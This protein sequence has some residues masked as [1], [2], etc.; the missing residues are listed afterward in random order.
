[1]ANDP[2]YSRPISLKEP[3]WLT[4][5]EKSANI[6]KDLKVAARRFLCP[7][8][9]REFSLFQSRAVACKFCPQANQNCPNV[10]CPHC[11]SE[12][13]IKGFIVPDKQDA[14]RINNYTDNV[15]NNFE[16]TYNRR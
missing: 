15:F 8:C 11:D 6:T 2:A 1:M 5:E 14:T 16:D 3:M 9:G 13:P 12:F 7:A 10:R 4:P